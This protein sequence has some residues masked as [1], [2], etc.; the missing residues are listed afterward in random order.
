MVVMHRC[1]NPPCVNPDHLTAG[2]HQDNM[3]DKANKGRACF[4]ERNPMSR[5]SADQAREIYKSSECSRV[6]ADRYGVHVTHVNR[7]KR[8]AKWGRV[9]SFG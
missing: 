6:L 9:T 2:T 3:A 4:G 8:G 7:I 5:L 1:D